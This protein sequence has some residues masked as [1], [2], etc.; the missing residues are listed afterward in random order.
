MTVEIETILRNEELHALLEQS[1]STGTIRRVELS[2]VL[3]P[4]ELDPL[5]TD[6]LFSELDRRGIELVEEPEKEKEKE[7]EQ[8]P[9]A[10]TQPVETTTD[11]LQLFLREAGRHPLLTAAQEV[12]LAKR[13]ERGDLNAK[14]T[15]IQS[16]LRLVVSIAKNYRNQGLPFLDLIQ[17]G[18]LGLIRAVEKFDWRR[19]YKFSTYATWWIRQAVARA[20]ADKA[21]TIR[22]PV[23]IVER[24]Q[25]MNRAERTLWM[26][27]GREPTLDEIAD[28]ASL[29]IEQAREVRAAAR[30]S[31]SLDQPVGEQDDAVFGDF[32]AGDDPLPEEKVEVSLRSQALAEALRALPQRERQVLVLRYGLLDEEPKTLEEIGR[33]LGLTRERVRQI[34][35]ESLRRLATLREMQVVASG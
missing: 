18:T 4:L 31:A 15:M 24:L 35:L 5:E 21:R 17:E 6:A 2:D 28:E 20:L 12:E 34:E 26:E 9:P 27:L 14:S 25:K 3:E 1:E 33:R 22:M 23:H 11:A 13:I 19:G 8:P 29:P 16:N 30:A 7:K 10:A 32:V